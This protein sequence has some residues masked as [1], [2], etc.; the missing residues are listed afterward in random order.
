[1]YS[2]DWDWEGSKLQAILETLVAFLGT[3]AFAVLFQVPASNIAPAGLAGAL[4]RSVYCAAQRVGFNHLAATFASAAM[5]SVMAEWGARRLRVPVS[6]LVVPG[7]IPLVPGADA[8][9]AML[10]FLKGQDQEGL[11]I[12]IRTGLA[13]LSVAAGIVTASTLAR[14]VKRRRR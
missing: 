11:R 7:I 3:A 2:W 5:L 10:A 12:A 8:Y 13:A 14:N 4:A 1:V 6:V 9:F